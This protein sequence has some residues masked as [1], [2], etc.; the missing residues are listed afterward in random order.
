MTEIFK[1]LNFFKGFFTQADDWR[2]EQAYHSGRMRHHARSLHTAGIVRGFLEELDV[3]LDPGGGNV[4]E[5]APGAAVDG[6]G[7][8]LYLSAPTTVKVVPGEFELPEAVFIVLRHHEE[9]ADPRDNVAHPEYSG[10]AFVE[11]SAR[12][13]VQA[14]APGPEAV[15]LARIVLR[16]DG[17]VGEPSDPIM[18]GPNEIDRT[19]VAWAG[20]RIAFSRPDAASPTIGIGEWRGG[21]T[22]ATPSRGLEPSEEEDTLIDIEEARAGDP[23]R[24]YLANVYPKAGQATITCFIQT[25]HTGDG[26]EYRLIIKNFGTSTVPVDY[27]VYRLA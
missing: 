25:R 26:V 13:E 17:V 24:L 4:L 3:R 5:V 20:G 18:P 15:E 6:H 8:E 27:R 21:S 9:E 16:G 19:R 2:T 1:R 12:V 11:E 22:N 23:H 14:E 7:R 10:H